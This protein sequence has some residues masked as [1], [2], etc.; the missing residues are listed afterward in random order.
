MT[1]DPSAYAI[2]G[3][4]YQMPEGAASM[5]RY[6]HPNSALLAPSF[7]GAGTAGP[8]P[9][10]SN[11]SPSLV[12]FGALAALPMPSPH[13]SSAGPYFGQVV[14]MG[15]PPRMATAAG[16]S[17]FAG[18]PYG[19]FQTVRVNMQSFGPSNSGAPGPPQ[20][21][22]GFNMRPAGRV[23]STLMG[24]TPVRN[25]ASVIRQQQV[26]K[27]APVASGS[28]AASRLSNRLNPNNKYFDKELAE[29]YKNMGSWE[30]QALWAQDEFDSWAGE[31][32]N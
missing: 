32:N 16:V 17:T 6:N 22:A 11:A 7:I 3:A 10:D 4:G 14:A 23:S 15:Q 9:R 26:P 28:N 8:A 18:G 30:R 19:D 21:S 5:A 2:S 12:D 25:Q 27:P 1:G 31:G 24:S 13:M 29:R 20:F